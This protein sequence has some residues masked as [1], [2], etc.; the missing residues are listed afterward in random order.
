MAEIQFTAERRRGEQQARFGRGG[1]KMTGTPGGKRR[2][3]MTSK[4]IAALKLNQ[5]LMAY[6]NFTAAARQ[7]AQDEFVSMEVLPTM[8]MKVL[9]ATLSF[10][11][12]VREP[13]PANFRDEVILPYIEGLLPANLKAQDRQRL[14]IR[15][16]AQILTYIRAIQLHREDE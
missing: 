3:L 10:L 7:Q 16:K 5:A 2:P 11:Y 6:G 1:G 12:D 15:F 14:I 9:A 13:T 8:N 4:E